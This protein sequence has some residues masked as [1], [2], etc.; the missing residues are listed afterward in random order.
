MCRLATALALLVAVCAL[1]S[2]AAAQARPCRFDDALSRAAEALLNDPRP[3]T[4]IRLLVAA[5]S[6]GATAPVVTAVTV[7]PDAERRVRR[8]LDR[9][10]AEA[11]APLIC[12]EARDAER[13]LVLAAVEAATMALRDGTTLVASLAAGFSSPQVILR[14]D[15]GELS[16]VPVTRAELARGVALPP[17]VAGRSTLIQL[18]AEG[19]DGPR[20]V[21]EL[22]AGGSPRD[23]LSRPGGAD[24]RRR[25]AALRAERDA[26][27]LRDNRLLDR[28]ATRHA[29]SVCERGRV[30][31]HRDGEDPETRLRAEG[32][33]S[34]AVGETV[35]RG[36]SPAAA[37]DALEQSPSHLATL[38][39]RRFTDLGLGTA[40][41]DEGR[42]C[43]VVLLSAWPRFTGR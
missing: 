27:P 16:R 17:R 28:E 38:A 13:R 2:L 23:V 14:A 19:P 18:L 41:D 32:I 4:P 9:R 22:I 26:S 15:D 6:E 43:L 30:S 42:T 21:A 25:V 7:A 24:V 39:D 12:G 20:P 34:R 8:W 29:E 36:E 10:A 1:P 5:R 37:M 35:A 33:V 40:E 31:H 3:P 11:D